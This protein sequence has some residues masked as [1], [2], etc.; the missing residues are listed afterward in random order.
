MKGLV[1]EGGGAKG[2][3]Q[4]GAYK[5]LR[6][7]GMEFQGVCG[8]SI[9]ALNGAYIVQDDIDVIEEIWTKY[10]YTSFMNIE[11]KLY[12]QYKDLDF[13]PKNINHV[14]KLINKAI[15]NEGIDISP[16]KKLL[17]ETL[18]EDKI[19]NSNK[20]FAFL[21]V[22][23]NKKFNPHPMYI[24]DIEKGRL[25]E[26]L[27]TSANLPIFKI[28]KLD[29]TIYLDGM[30]SENIPVSLLEEKGYKDLVVIRLLDDFL[31]KM[32]LNKYK[33]LNIKTIVPS[34]SLGGCLNKDSEHAK[35]NIKLGYL[36][37]MKSY[38]RYEGVDYYFEADYKFDE[39]YCF[40][41]IKSL[42][43]E[44]IKIIL[45]IFNLK[46]DATL[47]TLL[48]II[49][50]KCGEILGLKPEFT[51]KDL[52]YKIYERK[53]QENKLNRIVLYDFNKVVELIH[54]NINN[55]NVNLSNIKGF[56]KDKII[57][58]LTN[59]LILDFKN[60]M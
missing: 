19:R 45:E 24:E 28:D 27:I 10:D 56:K 9:G 40:N 1:L 34:E 11:E 8:T 31:G 22:S 39:D 15:K 53:L 51:Y 49:V 21:A 52:F 18:D 32:S 25:V 35:K 47:R 7:L 12:E 29:D 46:N 50:P 6:D 30:F 37:T 5:A 16:L 60:N 20:D 41:K 2:S 44:T 17:K 59:T 26:Y 58:L 57:T 23:W 48:E 36:D 38:K 13:T 42:N 14:I 4:I 43:E 3:Y 33:D 55:S 54:K